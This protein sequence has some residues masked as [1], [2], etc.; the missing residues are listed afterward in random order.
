M[1]CRKQLPTRLH[2]VFML[3]HGTF[4][5][6]QW[7]GR[8]YVCFFR[9]VNGVCIPF[10]LDTR[11]QLIHAQPSQHCTAVRLLPGAAHRVPHPGAAAV[12]SQGS[13]ARPETSAFG[14]SRLGAPCRGLFTIASRH[15]IAQ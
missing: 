1:H 2:S 10:D 9:A 6:W 5:V 4:S 7:Q 12:L 15:A 11:L 8:V 3:Q 14:A 13:A